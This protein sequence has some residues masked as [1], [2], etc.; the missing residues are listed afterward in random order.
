[1]RTN[2]VDFQIITR[3]SQC[4]SEPC[5][6]SFSF[7]NHFC[8]FTSG[9]LTSLAVRAWITETNAILKSVQ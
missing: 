2:S 9:L 1:M 6:V 3:T 8:D 7:E 4:W 5:C